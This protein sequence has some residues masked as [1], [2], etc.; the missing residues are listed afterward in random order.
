M[1]Q[2]LTT[3]LSFVCILVATLLCVGFVLGPESASAYRSPGQ[4]RGFVNDFAG[5]LSDQTKSS[6]EQTLS[7]FSSETSNQIVVVSVMSLEGDSIEN[8]SNELFRE[9]AIGQKDKNNGV[10]LLI[11]PNEKQVR[12]EVG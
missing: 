1:A 9:W 3:I 10:L 11:A 4:P 6:L 8:Y 7:Q 2:R 12:I 5:V